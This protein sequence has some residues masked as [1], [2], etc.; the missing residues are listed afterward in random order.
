MDD[1]YIFCTKCGNKC[2]D[3]DSFCGKCGTKLYDIIEDSVSGEVENEEYQ[4]EAINITLNCI[5]KK[6]IINSDN[7]I[8]NKLV[9]KNVEIPVNSITGIRYEEG[10]LKKNGTL[11]IRWHGK[12]EIEDSSTFY[13][14]NN[15][16]VEEIVKG[17]NE[18]I[19]NPDR[20]LRIINRDKIGLLKQV[21][22]GVRNDKGFNE[23]A[24]LEE[25][26]R[27]GIPY[28]PKCHSTSLSANK[29]GW[30]LSSGLIGSSKVLV[31]CLN[32]GHQFKP[33]K[34]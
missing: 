11:C 23:K 5:G 2:L 8:I 6:I 32:C 25:L 27:Q 13:Y 20:P 21:S 29:R 4:Q 22:M 7:I 14:S 18:K 9:G 24:K 3:G 1:K 33:G 34:K 19:Q 10:S 16:I 17:I 26:E 15:D 30:K 12:K 31:T 28:C